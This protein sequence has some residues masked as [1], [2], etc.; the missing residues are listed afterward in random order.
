MKTFYFKK[1]LLIALF[2][3]AYIFANAQ[4]VVVCKKDGTKIKVPYEQL[5]SITT[6]NYDDEPG[7]GDFEYENN[8]HK[9]VDLGLTSGTKWATMNVGASSP[10]DYGSYFSWGE[11]TPKNST[12][13]TYS[14]NP[15]TLPLSRDAAN[16]NWGS[17]WRMPTDKEIKELWDECVWVWTTLNGVAGYEVTS[18]NNSNSIFLPAAGTIYYDTLRYQEVGEQGNYWSSTIYPTSSAH[19]VYLEF[20]RNEINAGNHGCGRSWGNSIRPVFQDE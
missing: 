11:T 6:Y 13:Y 18:P 10:S 16:A 19:A 4:G 20:R 14:S 9:Y 3:I 1:P 17:N 12:K 15:T 8:G 2:C 5:D 7:I